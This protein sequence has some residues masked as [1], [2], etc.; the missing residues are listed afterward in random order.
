MVEAIDLFEADHSLLGRSV[1]RQVNMRGEFQIG[2][3]S[4][5]GAPV[6]G[7]RPIDQTPSCALH[8]S[9]LELGGND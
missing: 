5:L 2:Q 6:V 8:P 4:T 9:T 1:Q 7:G 3:F